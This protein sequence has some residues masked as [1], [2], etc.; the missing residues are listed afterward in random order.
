[1]EPIKIL[2]Y[3]EKNKIEARTLSEL[4]EKFVA[5]RTHEI[6]IYS[7]QACHVQDFDMEKAL[8]K[9]C[10]VGHPQDL[11]HKISGMSF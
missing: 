9:L 1:M 2:F 3:K 10:H 7:V 11:R 5:D 8:L 4:T 6:F